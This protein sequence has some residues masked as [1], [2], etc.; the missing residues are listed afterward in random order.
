MFNKFLK[1]R[2]IY[3]WRDVPTNTKVEI[4][5]TMGISELS[6]DDTV[7]HVDFWATE[8][9]LLSLG[10]HRND[11]YGNKDNRSIKIPRFMAVEALLSPQ[12]F[13]AYWSSSVMEVTA[14]VVHSE[15]RG[16][17]MLLIRLESDIWVMHDDDCVT[18]FVMTP[19]I[20]RYIQGGN[21]QDNVVIAI[22]SKAGIFSP[23]PLKLSDAAK[24]SAKERLQDSIDLS[25]RN[26]GSDMSREF[27]R[28]RLGRRL[29]CVVGMEDLKIKVEK[30][31]VRAI[32]NRAR[33]K[34]KKQVEEPLN[35]LFY[36]P[37]GTGKTMFA[38]LLAGCLYDVGILKEEKV[39]EIQRDNVVA[40]YVGESEKK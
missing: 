32:N 7:R 15:V 9:S 19:G 33:S 24:K 5:E 22:Y 31:A 16:H 8:P 20:L 26:S 1:D 38:R 30:L 40:Q 34:I 2:T 21:R 18:Q 13:P 23:H 3:T 35:L 4:T 36:G 37:P 29:G 27:V 11:G 17:V 25:N 6:A 28:R 39:V 14:I 12:D 10:I